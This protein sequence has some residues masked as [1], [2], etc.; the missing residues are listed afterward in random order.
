[1]IDNIATL[2]KTSHLANGVNTT[3]KA[4]TL[5]A[6][7]SNQHLIAYW[8]SD[9][10]YEQSVKSLKDAHNHGAESPSDYARR[11]YLNYLYHAKKR[12]RNTCYKGDEKYTRHFWCSQCGHIWISRLS[13]RV[14]NCPK[15]MSQRWDRSGEDS[16]HTTD[17][18]LICGKSLV[19]LGL[20]PNAK[21]CCK[22]CRRKA[23]YAKEKE[24][25]L[26]NG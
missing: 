6:K 16:W 20:R 19:G 9:E 5:H 25:R 1:M 22:T 15:C 4:A 12:K 17:N 13:H 8:I 23:W 18:C 11:I 21:Y 3:N 24:V 7:H 14:T 10:D 26:H 2:D